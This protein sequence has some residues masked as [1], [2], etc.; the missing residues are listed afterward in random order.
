MILYEL[1]FPSSEPQQ[2][3]YEE[4]DPALAGSACQASSLFATE[5]WAQVFEVIGREAREEANNFRN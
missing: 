5:D 4:F 2:V 1:Y 3:V